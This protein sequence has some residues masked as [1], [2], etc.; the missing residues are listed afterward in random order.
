MEVL[1]SSPVTWGRPRQQ[2]CVLVA[3]TAITSTLSLPVHF[4][5]CCVLPKTDS[6][7]SAFLAYPLSL[8]AFVPTLAVCSQVQLLQPRLCFAGLLLVC[9]FFLS[10]QYDHLFF[11]FFCPCRMA[12]WILVPRLV[13]EPV[14]HAVETRSPNHWTTREFPI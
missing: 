7:V 9:F 5:L 2:M 4:S 1:G 3:E 11:F 10:I 13:I 8:F 12:C 6:A 14:P